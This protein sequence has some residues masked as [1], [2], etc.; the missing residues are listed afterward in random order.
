MI[1]YYRARVAAGDK[2]ANWALAGFVIGSRIA[3][4]KLERD[5]EHDADQQGMLMMARAGYHPDFVFA[6]HHRAGAQGVF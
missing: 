3:F 2:S 6:L 4:K 5:Q 1:Q